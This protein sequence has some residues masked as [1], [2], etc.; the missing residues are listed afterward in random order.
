MRVATVLNYGRRTLCTR[1]QGLLGVYVFPRYSG[2]RGLRTACIATS[3][4]HNGIW[5]L[6]G[7]CQRW[8]SNIRTTDTSKE[9][10]HTESDKVL[11][12]IEDTLDDSDDIELRLSDGVLSINTPRGTFVLNKHGVTRQIWLSS[13]LSGPSK[14]NYHGSKTT[15]QRWLGERDEHPLSSLLKK[16]FT[17][18]LGKDVSFP[19]EF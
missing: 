1:N 4:G 15:P 7:L 18:V 17:Q 16:E 5:S 6:S 2:W 14:Y 11:H 12:V 3:R 8:S 10:F 19:K 13:P 9:V